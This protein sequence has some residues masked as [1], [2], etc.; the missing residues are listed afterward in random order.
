MIK[1][2]FLAV[3]AIASVAPAYAGY[4]VCTGSGTATVCQTV[5]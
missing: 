5:P 1:F 2:V 4:T 3:L